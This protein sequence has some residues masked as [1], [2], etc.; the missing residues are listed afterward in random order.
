MDLQSYMLH[1]RVHLLRSVQ[2]RLVLQG[3]PTSIHNLRPC[4]KHKTRLRD[5]HPRF[6]RE[7]ESKRPMR[8]QLLATTS[9]PHRRTGSTTLISSIRKLE[10]GPRSREKHSAIFI[11]WRLRGSTTSTRNWIPNF[12]PPISESRGDMVLM[13]LPTW[14]KTT[15]RLPISKLPNQ[16]E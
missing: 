9:V 12:L 13:I 11:S 6:A 1:R 7:V 2:N 3:R 14:K 8:W 15:K 10:I 16:F 4:P 5:Q